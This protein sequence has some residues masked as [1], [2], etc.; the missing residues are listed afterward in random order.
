MTFYPFH[1]DLHEFAESEKFSYGNFGL[2]YNKLIPNI[3]PANKDAFYACNNDNDK[4][5]RTEFYKTTYNKIKNN[6]NLTAYLEKKH[7]WQMHYIQCME[8]KGFHCLTFTCT[9]KAPLITGLGETH[10]SETSIVLDHTLGIPYIPAT[11]IKGIVRFSHSKQLLFDD[12]GVFSDT[13]VKEIKDKKN[14]TKLILDEKNKDTH[15]PLFFGGDAEGQEGQFQNKYRTYRGSIS[16][17]DAYPVS[18][19]EIK[20]D[21]INPHYTNYYG[22]KNNPPGDYEDPIPVNFLIVAPE[23]QFIVRFIL[24]PKSAAYKDQF[25]NVIKDAFEIEGVGAKTAIGYGRFEVSE[26]MPNHLKDTFEDYL[27]GVLSEEE[28]QKRKINN[29]VKRVNK[30]ENAGISQSAASKVDALFSEWRNSSKNVFMKN[31]RRI[32]KAFETKVKKKK[33]NGQPSK[34]YQTICEILGKTP[35]NE[36]KQS[37]SSLSDKNHK[38][39]SDIVKKLEAIIN[40]G[41]CSKKNK[42]KILEKHKAVYPELCSKIKKL[43]K[44]K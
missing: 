34:H 17:L 30:I 42:K 15:I 19:P 32:A 37:T 26:N 27:D 10:P 36:Q 6:N 11:S 31:D 2:W 44:K 12:V 43:P 7:H 14:S 13:F 29:F 9:S 18:V 28:K 21:I 38:P 16:F 4:Q 22:D 20:T 3:G 8:Q 40:K 1:K 39:D 33:S 35:D 23:T 41:F 24:D 25:I 5:K